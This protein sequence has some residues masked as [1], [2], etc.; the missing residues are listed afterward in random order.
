M[1]ID[2]MNREGMVLDGSKAGANIADEGQGTKGQEEQ[3]E[4]MVFKVG[5]K[6]YNH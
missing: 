4:G 6:Y 3:V 1:P 2:K 5:R